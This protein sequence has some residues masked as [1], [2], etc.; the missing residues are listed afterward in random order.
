MRAKEKKKSIKTQFFLVAILGFHG[1]ILYYEDVHQV[2]HLMNEYN[3][4]ARQAKITA[5]DQKRN[6]LLIA[7]LLKE[8]GGNSPLPLHFLLS[9]GVCDEASYVQ[10][11]SLAFRL[12]S[13]DDSQSDFV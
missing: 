9:S 11:V 3:E 5:T 7:V 13:G 8:L 12:Q 4:S 10:L 6:F 2:I 1:N